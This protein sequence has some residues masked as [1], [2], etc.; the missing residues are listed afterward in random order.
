M[1]QIEK[2]LDSA[3][4]SGGQAADVYDQRDLVVTVR[5]GSP[6]GR[7]VAALP[8]T[9]D[10]NPGAKIST[11]AFI[12]FLNATALQPN[13]AT[14]FSE[15]NARVVETAE[16]AARAVT[17][18]ITQ[19]RT[20]VKPIIEELTARVADQCE[21]IGKNPITD[22]EIVRR[23]VPAPLKHPSLIAS[24]KRSEEV[25]INSVRP[26]IRLPELDGAAILPLMRTGS[27][28]LDKTVSE[29]FA[30]KPEGWLETCWK[31]LYTEKSAFGMELREVMYGRN[32]LDVALFA[33]LTSRRLWD[34]PIEG[35]NMT[36][37]TYSETLQHIRNQA[38]K[39]IMS[40]MNLLLDEEQKGTLLFGVRGKVIEVWEDAYKEWV[41]A[42]GRNE[43][44]LGMVMSGQTHYT[45]SKINE[46]AQEFVNV[47]KRHET[48]NNLAFANTR[49]SR[50]RD[51]FRLEMQHITTN[52]SEEQFPQAQRV[53]ALQVF[54]RLVTELSFDDLKNLPMTCMR[55]VC[56]S[57]FPSY[58]FEAILESLQH[59]MDENPELEIRE[60]VRIV[61]DEHIARWVSTM[62]VLV[63][64]GEVRD[65]F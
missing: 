56:R 39:V 6:L 13:S 22:Y 25:E 54:N 24:V 28:E 27:A 1:S 37:A 4:Q 44:L 18:E 33:F 34:N 60:A 20:V 64:P 17:T 53:A 46:N 62:M 42:G 15:F 32:N 36:A 8:T 7:L 35:A 55:L 10:R 14:G 5:G 19:A 11:D 65:Q 2:S 29:Y 16:A 57:R 58:N 50:M 40:E 3:L 52:S 23:C 61:T 51:A 31:N 21:M 41:I 30:A 9:L 59:Q 38:A 47:W 48:M 49:L 63:A 43:V 26:N 45:V 12:S